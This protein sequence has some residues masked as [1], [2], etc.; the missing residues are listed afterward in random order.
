MIHS[1]S[2]NIAD[3]LLSNNCFEKE[4]IDIKI[5]VDCDFSKLEGSDIITLIGNLTDNAIEA[6]SKQNSNRSM[7]I[8]LSQKGGYYVLAVRNHIE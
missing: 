3:F 2:E 6:L 8:A 1:L 7:R 5:K 4:N